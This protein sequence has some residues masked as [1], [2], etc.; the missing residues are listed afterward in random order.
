MISHVYTTLWY[1]LATTNGVC[2]LPKLILVIPLSLNAKSN[3]R[4]SRNKLENNEDFFLQTQLE[5]EWN[6]NCNKQTALKRLSFML[7]YQMMIASNLML[8]SQN[9]VDHWGQI[10]ILF[11]YDNR[12]FTW[13][14]STLKMS[15]KEEGI[16]ISRVAKILQVFW[17]QVKFVN[18]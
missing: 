12:S 1:N 8:I 18:Q 7:L 15:S 11:S 4:T 16:L 10:K 6:T 3:Q 13:L 14:A 5:L 2:N 9:Y 17:S